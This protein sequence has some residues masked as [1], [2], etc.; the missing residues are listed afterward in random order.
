MAQSP[1]S[2]RR[3]YQTSR[4]HPRT[5]ILASS[6]S[7][8]RDTR[9]RI[10]S[11]LSTSSLTIAFTLALPTSTVT[12]RQRLIHVPLLAL[13]IPAIFSRLSTAILTF[14]QAVEPNLQRHPYVNITILF[15]SPPYITK[16]FFP[17]LYHH[18]SF[19]EAVEPYLQRHPYT[20]IRFEFLSS[21]YLPH[22]F[23]PPFYLHFNFS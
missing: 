9:L 5:Y 3:P 8:P 17:L 22:D 18:L 23:F 4:R 19:L 7:S 15:F 12:L 11:R 2:R 1:P 10:F 21:P 6:D 14:I 20:N 16:L 13:H